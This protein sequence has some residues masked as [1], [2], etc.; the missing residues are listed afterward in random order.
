LVLE[1]FRMHKPF[2]GIRVLELGIFHAGLGGTAIL[3]DLGAEVIKIEQLVIIDPQRLIHYKN[4]GFRL[5]DNT[6]LLHPGSNRGEKSITINLEHPQGKQIAYNMV[7]K[8]DVIFT[9][10]RGSTVNKML[11]DYQNRF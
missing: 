6:S 3:C 1:S 9:N 2:E 7:N 5:P 8:S 4:I 10:L 11:I